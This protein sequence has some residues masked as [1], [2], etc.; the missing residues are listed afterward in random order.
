MSKDKSKKAAAKKKSPAANKAVA[1]AESISGKMDNFPREHRFKMRSECLDKK[2]NRTEV[3]I[4]QTDPEGF[5]G[6]VIRLGNPYTFDLNA[7]NN[8]RENPD[9]AAEWM[10]IMSNIDLKVEANL[11]AIGMDALEQARDA[12]SGFFML[13]LVLKLA[14]T[15]LPES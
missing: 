7:P 11:T 12:V 13:S 3:L 6:E 1:A 8:L 5:L 14:G 4:I 10:G 2:G 9:K 15:A